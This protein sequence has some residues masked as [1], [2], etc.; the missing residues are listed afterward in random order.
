MGDDTEL[1][2]QKDKNILKSYLK[3]IKSNVITLDNCS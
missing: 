2:F 3:N 1:Y